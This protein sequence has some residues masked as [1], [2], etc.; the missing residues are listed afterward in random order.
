MGP[1]VIHFS[2]DLT[3]IIKPHSLSF[4]PGDYKQLLDEAYVIS[5]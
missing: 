4:M 5:R 1:N 2:S 3:P